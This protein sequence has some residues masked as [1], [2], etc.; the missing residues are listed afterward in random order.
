M[1]NVIE[2]ALQSGMNYSEYYELFKRLV[3]EGRTTGESTHHRRRHDR[4]PQRTGNFFRN[5]N[6]KKGCSVTGSVTLV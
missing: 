2:K 4:H 6:Q 1:K 3:E 5:Y